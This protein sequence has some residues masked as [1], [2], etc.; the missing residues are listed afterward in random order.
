MVTEK[1]RADYRK[2]R[3]KNPEKQEQLRQWK[4]DNRVKLNARTRELRI[5]CK[6]RALTHYGRGELKWACGESGL[7]ALTLSHTVRTGHRPLK[8]GMQFYL[9]LERAG[10]PELPLLTECMNCNVCRDSWGRV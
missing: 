9:E 1:R 3:Q 4:H 10:Y 8:S 2:N 7:I 5:Q 6:V